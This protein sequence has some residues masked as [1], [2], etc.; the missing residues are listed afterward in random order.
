[1]LPTR[2]VQ[3]RGQWAIRGKRGKL[4]MKC[5]Q[6]ENCLSVAS[7]CSSLHQSMHQCLNTHPCMCSSHAWHV[8]SSYVRRSPRLANTCRISPMSTFPEPSLQCTMIE[9]VYTR[10]ENRSACASE[11]TVRE[12][13]CIITV[14]WVVMCLLMHIV[15]YSMLMEWWC[16]DVLLQA[17]MCVDIKGAYVCAC[18]SKTYVSKIAKG[19]RTSSPGS[20]IFCFSINDMYSASE[21]CVLPTEWHTGSSHQIT[22]HTLS[23]I[24]CN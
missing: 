17:C 18:R 5:Q 24:Q 8:P 9:G 22:R 3:M 16:M 11:N 6:S 4:M 21:M 10:S 2:W 12:K 14:C 7:C 19:S 23:D 20:C 13:V 1:M 15:Y